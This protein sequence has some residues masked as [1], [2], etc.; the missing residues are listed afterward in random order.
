MSVPRHLIIAMSLFCVGLSQSFAQT[1]M[2]GHTWEGQATAQI[3]DIK[4]HYYVQ[5]RAYIPADHLVT[6]VPCYF[7]QQKA[8]VIPPFPGDPQSWWIEVLGD[9]SNFS[10]KYPI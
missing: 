2:P 5:Y 4:H 3:G 7:G 1:T 8:S 9:A 6:F 10:T